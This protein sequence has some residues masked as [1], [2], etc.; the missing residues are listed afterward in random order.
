MWST[1]Y[2]GEIR[3]IQ[4]VTIISNQGIYSKGIDMLR[5]EVLSR[6]EQLQFPTSHILPGI[7]IGSKDN[8]D[9][10]TSE[11]FTK[12]GL[13]HIL[14]L[15]GFNITVTA[16]AVYILLRNLPYIVRLTVSAG[17][18]FIL[19]AISGSEEPAVRAYI[20]TLII[21]ALMPRISNPK[22]AIRL[23]IY[24][25]TIVLLVS[26][27]TL[28]SISFQLSTLATL[29]VFT[30]GSLIQSRKH[31]LLHPLYVAVAATLF[32]SPT[33]LY[34]SGVLNASSTIANIVAAPLVPIVMGLG[35]MY[36]LVPNELTMLAV[37][38]VGS[39][40]YEVAHA[41]AYKISYIV[42]YPITHE[43]LNLMNIVL[44]AA[45]LI[46]THLVCNRSNEYK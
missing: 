15:S 39:A 19:V 17:V 31:S 24:A 26:P 45:L 25:A 1:G 13:I 28:H 20:T 3:K 35:L 12:S 6:L 41:F 32:T 5:S 33:I 23:T 27:E 34:L 36:V 42:I 14:V 46:F 8:I 38:H 22:N 4:Q 7:L 2:I 18:T 44:I 9:S 10:A 43:T 40:L 30:S 37:Q 21:L 16:A 11:V 29:A